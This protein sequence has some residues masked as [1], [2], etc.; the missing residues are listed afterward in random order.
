MSERPISICQSICL[1]VYLSSYIYIHIH[2]SYMYVY[3]KHPFFGVSPRH[4]GIS[5]SCGI[6]QNV[7][8]SSGST[9]NYLW[10]NADFPWIWG[11]RGFGRTMFGVYLHVEETK[12][13]YTVLY[14]YIIIYTHTLC[15]VHIYY[16]YICTYIL[17][18]YIY[19]ISTY[20][21]P[22][23]LCGGVLS[24]DLHSHRGLGPL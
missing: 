3:K 10:E 14:I 11:R 20:I 21:F 7:S 1:S 13:M 12:I 2:T 5:R 17:Y 9:H 23:W 16:I 15:T 22:H 24:T 6:F 4:S 19:K 8:E 18:I